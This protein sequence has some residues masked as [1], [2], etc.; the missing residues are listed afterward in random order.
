[1]SVVAHSRFGVSE[2]E[3]TAHLPVDFH[4]A[5]LPFIAALPLRVSSLRCE[6]GGGERHPL[7]QLVPEGLGEDEVDEGIQAD[8]EN[9]SHT[10][11]LLQVHEHLVLRAPPRLEGVGKPNQVVRD[12]ADAED[13]DQHQNVPAG[14]G[15]LLGAGG[16]HLPH[17]HL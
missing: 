16:G 8:V 9:G 14:L 10:G 11:Q 3:A 15:E 5:L 7:V 6:L 13:D 1:M 4:G 2:L 17:L 12:K